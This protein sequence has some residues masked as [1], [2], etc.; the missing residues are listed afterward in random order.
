MQHWLQIDLD[1]GSSLWSWQVARWLTR[2]LKSK[3][4]YA[5]LEE[6]LLPD[7]L[8]PRNQVSVHGEQSSIIKYWTR[9]NKYCTTL[10]NG[11]ESWFQVKTGSSHLRK[12]ET[13]LG[14]SGSLNTKNNPDQSSRVNDKVYSVKLCERRERG[15]KGFKRR[16]RNT[17]R[18]GG[19]GYLQI[20]EFFHV[21]FCKET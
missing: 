20:A 13:C 10:L 16:K 15:R 18:E 8:L 6:M 7:S 14:M 11:K 5:A 1:S 3:G 21:I 12:H 17:L 4:L 2:F 19:G 9:P